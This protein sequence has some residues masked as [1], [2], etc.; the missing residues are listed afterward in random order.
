MIGTKRCLPGLTK[1]RY[2]MASSHASLSMHIKNLA[3]LL[4][5][6]GLAA[7]SRGVVAPVN[8]PTTQPSQPSQVGDTALPPR[9]TETSVPSIPSTRLL[10]IC[11]VREPR[12]LFLY[13]AVSSSE[14]SVLSAIYDG[15]ID[16]LNFNTQ[17]VILDKL[18]S[19]ADG[20]AFFQPAAVGK[21]D[22]VVDAQGNMTN[23]AEG[24]IYRPSGCSEQ[25]C[26]RAYSGTEPVQMDQLVL[27]FKLLPDLKWSDGSPLTAAD[28]V[29][30]FEVARNL[31]SS[32]MPDRVSRT[33][34]YKAVDELTVEWVGIPG[35]VDSSYQAKFYS[36]LPQHAWS[37]TPVDELP[38]NEAS[39]RKPQG[40]GAYVIDEWVAGDHITLHANP[41]YFRA[42]E[43][44]PY[45][46][47]LVYRFVS[48][49]REA[50]SAVLAGE[51]DLVDQATGLESQTDSLLQ[52]RDEGKIALIFQSAFAW[53]VLELNL[54]PLAQDRPAFFASREVRRAVAMC[55]DRQALVDSISGGQVQVADSYVPAVHPLYYSEAV[56]Y[57]YDPQAAS[58]LLTASGWLD[59]DGD[60]S[61]PRIAQ[62]VEGIADGT[63]FIVQYLVSDDQ[64]RQAAAHM[65][66]ADLRQCGIQ[67]D[68]L[69]LPVEE[70]LA[71]GPD[72]PVFGRQFDLAQFAW[73]TAAE[74]PCSLYL[75][76]EIP[77]TYP[78]SSKGWGG[79]NAGAYSSPQ[80]DQ[81]CLDA[82]NS[83]PDM[84]QY[85]DKHAEAQRIFAEDLPALPLFWH[86]RLV[87]GRPDLCDV[88]AGA[89]F[90]SIF[91]ELELL[92]YG[93]TCP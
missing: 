43:G 69:S 39:S 49:S 68:I 25:A 73:M 8:V 21:G 87:V 92:N 26:A 30:S 31:Y 48:D 52:L 75:S 32:A 15:P 78:A 47:N 82:L 6:F 77:G 65:V 79:V 7:C 29:Y 37:G 90:G 40:W 67:A 76:R 80:Y 70:Y 38:A 11:L 54:S 63:A 4:L 14:Q 91:T 12:T 16:T 50:L 72:G 34:A 71:A 85:T 93:E 46:N 88:P 86:Y 42:D 2:S 55:I 18:P 56:H 84:P 35:F 45:F 13:E 53:D 19:T 51:C 33:A 59:D 23:L 36:P 58:K 66:Q 17:A 3:I 20:D 10:T 60:L 81:A 62:G 61:T 28:S 44:L 57:A 41:L 83:L 89:F 22:L 9:L 74:P 24:T 27:H 5:L 64:E 1:I